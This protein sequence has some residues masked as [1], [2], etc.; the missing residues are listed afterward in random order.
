MEG[1]VEGCKL[2]VKAFENE[3]DSLESEY[4]K[5]ISESQKERKKPYAKLKAESF[6]KDLFWKKL[7]L[8]DAQSTFSS[9]PSLFDILLLPELA[10]PETVYRHFQ[11]LAINAT[12]TKVE[13]KISRCWLE[14]EIF[15]W[16]KR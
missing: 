15:S 7:R 13:E 10:P 16:I 8:H 12:P 3:R 1:A 6:A 11:S 2:I 14:P 5:K 4:M 9:H